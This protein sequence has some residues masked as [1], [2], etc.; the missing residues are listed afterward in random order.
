MRADS[1]S[2]RLVIDLMEAGGG[3]PAE[4]DVFGDRQVR[5]ET[6]LL[7]NGGDTDRFGLMGET[8]RCS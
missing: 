8:I 4:E 6:E 3:Q 7:V 5:A 2:M 1:D